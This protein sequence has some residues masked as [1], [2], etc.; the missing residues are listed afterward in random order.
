MVYIAS[1]GLG[2]GIIIHRI[3]VHFSTNSDFKERMIKREME[4]QQ[5]KLS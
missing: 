4:I 1:F 5:L 2:L 3:N